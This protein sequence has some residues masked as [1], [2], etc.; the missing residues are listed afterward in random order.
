[1]KNNPALLLVILLALGA[2]AALFIGAGSRPAPVV[3]A[4]P[5]AAAAPGEL[6]AVQD[7]SRT[8]QV[9]PPPA[10][11]AGTPAAQPSTL[12]PAAEALDLPQSV[13]SAGSSPGFAGMGGLPGAVQ[14]LVS[15]LQPGGSGGSAAPLSENVEDLQRQIIL[16]QGQIE[17]LQGQNDALKDENALLLQKLGT[18]G[19]KSS[20]LAQAAAQMK[21]KAD[22]VPPDF[23]GMGLE[24]MKLRKLQALPMVT[25]PVPQ[26]VVEAAILQ[27]LR[28]QQP[29]EA[30][31]R[32]ARGLAALD[33][34]PQA[35]DPL[36]LKAAL[37]ARVL[38]GWYV[39]ET[40]TL[41]TVDPATASAPAVVAN[42]PLAIAY[43][44]LM[45]EF[46]HT[47]FQPQYGPLST[48]SRLAR[49]SL[50]AGDAG[51]TRFLHSMQNPASAP[52]DDLPA[53]DPDH[54]L[55]QVAM[56]VFLKELALFPFSRGFDFAQSLHSAGSFAQLDAAY[57]R[58][59]ISSAEV[60]E[61]EAYLDP[62]RPQP[63]SLTVAELKLKGTEPLL[64]DQLGKFACVTALRFYN[65]DE[66]AAEGA[67]G[68]LAD[69]LLV[70]PG[71][72]TASAGK[73]AGAEGT[74][75]Q[76]RDHAAWLTLFMDKAAAEA[77]HKA[78]LNCLARRYRTPE[79]QSEFTHEGRSAALLRT[80]GGSGV[81][82]ILAGDD[83]TRE[84]LK[85]KFS[86]L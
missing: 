56:P 35:L 55:N 19:M 13:P 44:Q 26:P 6:A 9:Q 84:E 31:L 33:W 80:H 45:R 10:E 21:A 15:V 7:V 54:P 18:L 62:E 25:T 16:L 83:A 73:G 24:M 68:L 61:P 86:R 30:A 49:E 70:W 64:D 76:P 48:D 39:D 38:G 3:A 42:E 14:P 43:G 41:L 20:D 60:I 59:P 75:P 12:R 77:F 67:R 34:I 72:T 58:P 51:L 2:V 40:E 29:G 46:G 47:L 81:V 36:P 32:Q 85:Q 69:R 57:S 8:A 71:S 65:T 50:M 63:P 79:G 5:P 37:L 74:P 27:W 23:V 11:A 17:Y 4:L 28:R 82:L 78:M 66:H 22:D 53:E 52:Q 1:M